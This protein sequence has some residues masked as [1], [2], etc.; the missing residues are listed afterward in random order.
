MVVAVVVGGGGGEC[1]GGARSVVS[2][3]GGSARVLVGPGPGTWD[4]VAAQGQAWVGCVRVMRECV[5]VGMQAD[6]LTLCGISRHAG[7]VLLLLLLPG[8]YAAAAAT[9]VVAELQLK[10]KWRG[11]WSQLSLTADGL[12][13]VAV[14]A[15]NGLGIERWLA[16][17][18]LCVMYSNSPVRLVQ[19][20]VDVEG[21]GRGSSD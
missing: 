6:R 4:L 13:R 18:P 11:N 20:R 5:S 9:A 3:G 12:K 21:R 19:E 10:L 16:V 17:R 7:C 1:L 8:F 14:F 2:Q 15:S